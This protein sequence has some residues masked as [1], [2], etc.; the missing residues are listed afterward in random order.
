[1]PLAEWTESDSHKAKQVWVE[2]QRQHDLS[3]RIGQTA[4][5]DP[6]SGR[7]WFGESILDIVSQRD[8]EGL[9]SPLFFERVGSDAYY[10]KGLQ[11]KSRL[12]Q[13]EE[14]TTVS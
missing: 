11:L 10:R 3:A 7:I 9:D 2:Y 6:H 8:A 13:A 1:M 5:I 14:I 4:G 12:L